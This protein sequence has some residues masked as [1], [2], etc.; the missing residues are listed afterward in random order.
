MSIPIRGV[1]AAVIAAAS[2]IMLSGQSPLPDWPQFRGPNRDGTI[3]AFTEPEAW[4]DRLRRRWRVIVGEGYATPILVADRVYVFSREGDRE[5][6]R[7][8]EADTGRT[9]WQT[10]YAA[11]VTVAP[12][13]RTHGPGPKSTPTFAD[14]RIF[15]LGMG[16][17][18]TA[19][20]AASGAMLWQKP[21]DEERPLYGTASSTLVDGDRVIV[22][23]GGHNSGALTAF[24]V[25]SGDVRWRWTGD[26][27][28]YASPIV[29][30]IDGVRQVIA[31]AQENLVGV[32]AD[33]GALLWRLPFSTEYTQNIITPVI[34]GGTLII[35]GY[36]RPMMALRVTR[37]GGRWTVEQ[38]WQNDRTSL[39]MAD[40]VATGNTL[41]G[42]SHR[43]SGQYFLVD[44][45]NG[46]TLW[47]GQPRQAEN[48]AIV[49]AGDVI[50]S[51]ED[52]GELM[53]GRVDGRAVQEVRRYTVADSATW[54]QPVISG[55]R[56]FVKDAT[57]VALW[58]P[59]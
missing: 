24:D 42:L 59:G 23:M 27:P 34:S 29:A 18:V 47:T 2:V 19:V 21:G 7:A 1:V 13:A 15:T 30:E 16:G 32:S 11:P 43:N 28:S 52:D 57:A 6:L 17:I 12:A 49:R 39:Y 5:V 26:G 25:R 31:L 40:A 14:G 33:T 38:V 20:D 58:T 44:I 53:I 22:H 45:R 35:S 9:V 56:L 48:A 10:G 54:A 50:F 37:A 51:L 36:Q 55:D 8:L 46:Q 3:A 41:F 4:P